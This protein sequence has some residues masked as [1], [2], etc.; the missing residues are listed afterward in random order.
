MCCLESGQK[1]NRVYFEVAKTVHN[2]MQS[3]L[4]IHML[5]KL[6]PRENL[7]GHKIESPISLLSNCANQIV[8][9]LIPVWSDSAKVEKVKTFKV[10]YEFRLGKYYLAYR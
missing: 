1:N 6:C 5:S 4:D 10:T 9:I 2:C 3:M 7:V 8:Q